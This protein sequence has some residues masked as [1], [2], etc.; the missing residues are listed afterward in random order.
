MTD[1]RP[2]EAVHISEVPLLQVMDTL[3]WR[4]VRRHLGIGA[5]GVNAYTAANAGDHVVEPHDETGAGAGQHEELYVVLA[6]RATFAIAGEEA[7][8]SAGT[9][10]FVRDP[11]ARREAVAAEAGTTILAIGGA[12]DEPFRVSAWEHYFA[13]APYARAG[14][15]DR[16]IALVETGLEEQ[17]NHPALLYNLACYE[18]LAGRHEEALAHLRQAVDLDRRTLAW[19]ASDGDFEP[20]RN[21]PA[22]PA[23]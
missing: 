23:G 4:P 7:E 22:F 21:D 2:F 16:A 12:R 13:A 3:A 14:D 1:E 9:L 11:A 18:S 8:S 6:G 5:F 15:Y 17:P 20:I 19:A 10:V